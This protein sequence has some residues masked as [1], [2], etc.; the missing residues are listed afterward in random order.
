VPRSWA[1]RA[2]VAGPSPTIRLRLT[3]LYG[4]VFLITGA[5][6]LT[7]GYLLVRQNLR[8]HH[9]VAAQ[10][11]AL[12]IEPQAEL[13]GRPLLF[14]P[15]SPELQIAHDVQSQIVGSAL[16][17]LLFEY[18]GALGLMTMIAVGT[19]WLLAGR[20][21]RPLR[22]IT[23]TARRVSGENLGERIAL[24][25]PA[26]ELKE[27]ADTFDGM[28]QRL[29]GAFASQRHFVANASHELR[30]PLAIMRTEVD[31]ALA[32]PDADATELRAMGEAVRETID[33][34]ERLIE[35]LLVLARSQAAAG[36][37][38]SVD[39]AALVADCITDLHARAQE[40]Q[41][42]VGTELEPA[43]TR[44]EPGLLERMIANLIDNG[45]R[46]NEAGGHLNVATHALDSH[47]HLTVANGGPVIDP[48][49]AQTLLEPFRRLD[50]SLDG[51]G[52]GLSIV[53]SVVQAHHGTIEVVAPRTGGLEVH[54]TLPRSQP[55]NSSVVLRRTSPAL[56]P[57]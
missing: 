24:S 40:A 4:L 15:G 52:L 39:L 32:D 54:I 26:D 7:I 23:A 33:R 29:D 41:V 30:T 47:I 5:V 28:L 22:D 21:L 48:A 57:S 12:G 38:E 46:H 10:L 14:A 36:R 56:T 20:A 55:R 31:V 44:G 19:G 6:L 25:G 17:R 27:L 49:D 53:R 9:I 18:L 3:V 50:R 1:E 2:R 43:W 45:I 42:T 13:F 51:V 16:N 11:K 8:G 35:S 37:E 34:C